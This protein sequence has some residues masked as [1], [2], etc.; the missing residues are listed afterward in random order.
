MDGEHQSRG[1]FETLIPMGMAA[2]AAVA[3]ARRPIWL[4]VGVLGFLGY[5]LFKQPGPKSALAGAYDDPV[6]QAAADSFP[7]SDPPSWSGSIAG[8]A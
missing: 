3:L 2:L 5:E 4:W 1:D 7:A 6:D 8:S